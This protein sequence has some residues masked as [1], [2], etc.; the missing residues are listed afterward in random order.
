MTN[1]CFSYSRLLWLVY[2]CVDAYECVLSFCVHS[3][4]TSERERTLSLSFHNIFYLLRF[5]CVRRY[6]HLVLGK[7]WRR[8]VAPTDLTIDKDTSPDLLS[9]ERRKEMSCS[10]HDKYLNGE[11]P[12]TGRRTRTCAFFSKFP[13]GGTKVFV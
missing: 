4:P 5:Y 6:R 9:L 7:C 12:H 8:E 2:A 3:D 10:S 13:P 1:V 11:E